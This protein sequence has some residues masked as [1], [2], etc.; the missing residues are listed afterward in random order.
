MVVEFPVAWG[1]MDAMGHVNNTKYFR[2]FE[3]GRLA[4]FEAV[5]MHELVSQTGVGPILATTDCRFRLPLTYPDT[6]LIG[7]DCTLFEPERFALR[8]VVVS[9]NHGKVAAEGEGVLVAF[10]YGSGRKSVW[11]EGLQ[12]RIERL[13]EGGS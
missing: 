7:V 5:G 10:D 4:W 3:D 13:R 12:E 9:K 2:W 1:D 6:V 8:H 11:P